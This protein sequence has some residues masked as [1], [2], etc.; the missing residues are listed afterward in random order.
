MLEA[1]ITP[2][3][4]DPVKSILGSGGVVGLV[5]LV[6]RW[7]R[8]RPR[9]RMHSV[10]EIFDPR[11]QPMIQVVITVE[12]E[13][14]GREATSIN[15]SVALRYISADRELCRDQ[16]QI[17]ETDRTLSPVAPK[18]LT[19]RAEMPAGYIFSHF[20]VL[21]LSFTRGAS[22]RYR[23]LNASGQTAGLFKFK[24]LEWVFRVFG[25]LPHIPG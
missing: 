11:Q 9:I 13:N 19:L 2:F 17:Q 12:L 1:V 20:R 8:G 18:S 16:F 10:R 4:A 15:P 23:V 5:V 7:W 24:I 25:A 22:N 3:L 14:I 6:I 21:T